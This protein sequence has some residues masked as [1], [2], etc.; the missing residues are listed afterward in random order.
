MSD[1]TTLFGCKIDAL[2]LRQA[3]GHLL[4]WVEHPQQ[5]CRYVVT[6]NVNHLALLERHE[7]FR[8]A[9][10]EASMILADGMPLVAAARLLRRPLPERVAGSDLVPALFEA[11]NNR[12]GLTVFLLGAMPGVADRAAESIQQRWPAVRVVG[13]CSPPLGFEKSPEENEKILHAIAAARPQ[14]LIVGLGAP[15]QELWTYEHRDRLCVSVALCVGATIDFLA[16]EK[17]RAPVWMRK[18]GL[19]WLHRIGSEPRRLAKR[20]LH[21]ALIFPRL[22][23]RELRA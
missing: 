19:E 8:K 14:V 18:T 7:T 21:D 23:V 6:P 13:T 16:G 22:L 20:Y 9:Y 4:T 3:V 17:S 12:G 15:K 10:A 11:A 5:R 2:K 1:R